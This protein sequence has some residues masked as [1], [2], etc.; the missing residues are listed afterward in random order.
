MA[1]IKW[2]RQFATKLKLSRKSIRTNPFKEP[3]GVKN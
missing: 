1:K 3:K 2:K